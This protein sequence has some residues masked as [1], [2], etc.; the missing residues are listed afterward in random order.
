M[1]VA[2]ASLGDPAYSD[3]LPT[4]KNHAA[5]AQAQRFLDLTE[6]PRKL[7]PK[8]KIKILRPIK[9]KYCLQEFKLS[10]T[11]KRQW[12]KSGWVCPLCKTDMCCM[13]PKERTLFKLQDEYLRTRKNEPLGRM[14]EE[15][16]SYAQ[17][18]L[19]KKYSIITT[20]WDKERV[21][22]RAAWY[23]IEHYYNKETF[24]IGVSFGAYVIRTLRQ[25]VFDKE[26]KPSEH[27]SIDM[28]N[29]D[30]KKI[31]EIGSE[32]LDVQRLEKDND[33]KML[34]PY[35][36][37][38]IFNFDEYSKSRLEELMRIVGIRTHLKHGPRAVDRLYAQFDR[39]GKE[40]Y[41]LTMKSLH[42]ELHDL[43]NV[44]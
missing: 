34:L 22:N 36:T 27:T 8:K 30:S 10:P 40:Q 41:T 23:L 19:K 43:N 21:A 11:K 2:C 29:D 17:S 14:Y 26:E 20:V 42:D 3:T 1:T 5:K 31:Y 39:V 16:R 9:C 7:K 32:D 33:K 25:A 12:V 18:I 13:P 4:K 38:F 24:K 15:L 44:Q 35:I 6:S 37:K 28:E